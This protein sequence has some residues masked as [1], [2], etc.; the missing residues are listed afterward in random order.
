[1][2]VSGLGGISGQHDDSDATQHPLGDELT[3]TSSSMPHK[4][5]QVDQH[6]QIISYL[7]N[8]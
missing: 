1:M 3:P 7:T 2:S 5:Y 6:G 8:E 4:L